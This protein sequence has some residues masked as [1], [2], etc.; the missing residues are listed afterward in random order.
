MSDESVYPTQQYLQP[1]WTFWP[2]AGPDRIQEFEALLLQE[3]DH[4]YEL[5][6]D[7]VIEFSDGQLMWREVDYDYGCSRW[8]YQPTFKRPETTFKP[9]AIFDSTNSW[10]AESLTD[11]NTRTIMQR[12]ITVERNESKVAYAVF[13][14]ECALAKGQKPIIHD[15][16][17]TS[18]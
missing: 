5:A 16:F 7:L 15:L 11:I 4:R 17:E 10:V 1:H 14:V 2:L 12:E 13:E 9:V 6:A 18:V 3:S 8:A